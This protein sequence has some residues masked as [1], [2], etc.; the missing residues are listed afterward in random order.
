MLFRRIMIAVLFIVLAGCGAEGGIVQDDVTPDLALE[1]NEP[2]ASPDGITFVELPP[3]EVAGETSGLPELAPEDIGWEPGPGEAGYP[4]TAGSDCNEGFC[5]R[6]AEG[7]Q[8]TQTCQ[9]EC[10]F[11]W[12]C[13]LHAASLP[14]EVYICAP[15]LVDL[16]RPCLANADCWASGVDSGESC[17]SYGPAGFFCGAA[18]AGPADC[19]TGYDCVV[20]EDASQALA[21]QCILSAG[22]CDCA[23]WFTDAQATTSCY[24][25][26]QWGKCSGERACMAAGLTDCTAAIPAME[27]CNGKDDDC[28]LEID[29]D[30]AGGE[31]PIA[32]Q[33]GSCQ[34]HFKCNDGEL[35]CSGPEPQ[36]EI[37]DGMDNDC[38]GQVDEGFPDTNSDGV[39]DCLVSD[40]DGDGIL[41]VADNCPAVPNTMQKDFDLDSTGDACD[42]DDDNDLVAD[43]ADCAPL[44]P[45]ISPKAQEVCN[46]LDDDCDLVVDEGSPDSD[47][48][49]LADC[50]DED[51]DGD[52]IVDALDCAPLDAA[53]FPGALEE[54]DGMD[55]DCDGDIDEEFA[56]SDDDGV[57]DCLDDDK[58]GDG[59]DNLN[60]NCPQTA[61]PEQTDLDMDGLGNKCDSDLD[62]DAIPNALDNCPDTQNTLQSDLDGD[63]AGDACDEDVDGDGETNE[64]DNCPLV[65]NPEQ[66]D[67]NGDGVGDACETDKDGDGVDDEFDCAPFE[68]A[69]YP[70]ADE[71]CDDLDNDCDGLVDE[72]FI[73]S[74]FDGIKDCADADDDND[75]EPDLD[76]CA[77][78]NAAVHHQALEVCDNLDNDCDDLI[79]EELGQTPCGLGNCF[80]LVDNCAAGMANVCNPFTGAAAE[81]CDGGD[82]DCDGIIDEDLGTASCGLG[83]CWHTVPLCQDG[84]SQ[85][86]DPLAGAVD[87][88]CD[89][90]DNNCNG[91]VDENMPTLACGKGQC[92]HTTPSCIGG[93]PTEC[94]AFLGALPESCDGL[95]NDCDDEVDED[96]GTTQCGLGQCQH[97]IDICFE[98]ILQVCNPFAGVQV[99]ICD[100][101]DNDCDGLVDE[102]LGV[103][104]CGK[105]VCE[106]QV[107]VCLDGQ[108]QVCDPLEGAGDE[109]CDGLDNNCSGQVDEGLGS[110]SCGIGPCEHEVANCFNGVAQECDPLEGAVDEK[111]DDV[112]NNCNGETDEGFPDFDNDGVLDCLDD[113]DDE[114]GDPDL[115]DCEPFNPDVHSAADE[116]C[117]N[118]KDDDCDPDTADDCLFSS[119]YT[120][121]QANP[122]LPSANY[123]VDPTGGNPLD[124]FQVQC[125]MTTDG[126]GWNVVNDSYTV[127]V[128][129]RHVYKEH[130][131][132]ITDYGYQPVSF[133]FGDVYVNIMFAGE[134]DDGN[135][136]INT[137]FDGAKINKWANQLC[138]VNLVQIGEWPRK[139]SLN[140]SQFTLG[141]QPE[142]D[143]DA[144]C[145][146]GQNHGIDYFEL[147]RF[148]AIPK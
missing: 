66:Q 9:Q 126:G 145:G 133:N 69:A 67:G 21:S 122:L 114:D 14:D 4:C 140:D 20:T 85:V 100:G 79:D 45:D 101:A 121:H 72:G 136:F 107:P 19:P 96:L 53:S 27:E 37:C 106:H 108:P 102:E 41:D 36:P 115:T 143:V 32:N 144:D 116:I 70:G 17:V 147:I 82:N 99:E 28:D 112:D 124:A 130:L 48:D 40:K 83:Q 1:L 35:S 65:P 118:D 61:N 31:C 3:V 141:A 63:Q 109:E 15:L 38:D 138:N 33:F 139:F 51:D 62:G 105:G 44:N 34:G 81:I 8:C 42:L 25:E 77:P 91:Q 104:A 12:Q 134:L 90:K 13:S 103:A 88:V 89:G 92:F 94:D 11:D 24:V 132:K 148:R 56:D 52:G 29:E 26:N 84:E 123:M 30:T 129:E 5:I 18:C 127:N 47:Y 74:D 59:V 22:L 142:G 110:T 75:G 86:C 78:T 16:C 113:D 93:I 50:I 120:L 97:T 60:D 95:D 58:D 7:M 57:A 137:Y 87:E 23:E 64:E 117:N 43:A 49:K 2:D 135:N 76:D 71:Q 80:H 10:P 125:D 54:C 119:C 68:P 131:F 39:K 128:V 98:G 111:C 6:T 146:N 55:N 73:D 46:G